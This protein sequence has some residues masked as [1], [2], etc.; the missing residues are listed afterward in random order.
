[1]CL[2]VLSVLCVLLCVCVVCGECVV[3]FG[4]CGL[5]ASKHLNTKTLNT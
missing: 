5:C 4:V 1:M 2:C 3:C